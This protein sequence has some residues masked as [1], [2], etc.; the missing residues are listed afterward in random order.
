M[1]IT[2]FYVGLI[3]CWCSSLL[4]PLPAME[5]AYRAVVSHLENPQRDV[6]ES[7]KALQG[8]RTQIELLIAK[9][10]AEL[11]ENDRRIIHIDELTNFSDGLSG[12]FSGL[13]ADPMADDLSPESRRRFLSALQTQVLWFQATTEQA[14][15]EIVAAHRANK[16][17]RF[18]PRPAEYLDREGRVLLP[19]EHTAAIERIKAI[20]PILEREDYPTLVRDHFSYDPQKP[21]TDEEIASSVAEIKLN[22]VMC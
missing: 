4:N 10:I 13:M 19:E 7:E 17:S 14:R 20:I 16:V 5:Q 9:P 21:L 22:Q 11:S 18:H 12:C 15:A 2:Y 8:L 1:K 3:L 6:G